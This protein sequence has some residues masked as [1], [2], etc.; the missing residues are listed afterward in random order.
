VQ[1]DPRLIGGAEGSTV[2]IQMASFQAAPENQSVQQL[3]DDVTEE[4]GSD[5]LLT[6]PLSAGYWSA[7]FFIEVLKKAGRNPS[8]EEFLEVANDG[9]R[10][11]VPDTVATTKWPKAHNQGSACG[12]LMEAQGEEYVIAV[13][14]TCG[15]VKKL[16]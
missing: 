11:G 3:I 4:F 13:P 12:S 15:K 9:F 6:Q 7:D 14:F 2:F 16:S 10:Y 5:Q 1:Y 8:Q